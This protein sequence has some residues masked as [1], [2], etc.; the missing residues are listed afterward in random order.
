MEAWKKDA[1]AHAAEFPDIEICGFVVGGEYVR[2]VNTHPNPSE[3]FRTTPPDEGEFDA[4]V[5]SHPNGNRYPS[6]SDMQSQ[7]AV[8]K[9]YYIVTIDKVYGP[10]IFGFGDQLEKPPLLGRKFRHGVTDCYSLVKIASPVHYPRI[11]NIQSR[12]TLELMQL[13]G[14]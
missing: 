6:K 7:L 10:E 3:N 4:V 9:P 5:H 14:V 13:L 2:G 8:Q 1:I 11:L 12:R